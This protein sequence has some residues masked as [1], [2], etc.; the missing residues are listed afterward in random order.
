MTVH[1]VRL[2]AVV[3]QVGLCLVDC[4][5]VD[6]LHG[7]G[8]RRVG[9]DDRHVAALDAGVEAVPVGRVGEPLGG[10]ANV[11][12][13]HES[14]A[15]SGDVHHVD[16]VGRLVG[17]VDPVS[18]LVSLHRIEVACG[19]DGQRGLADDGVAARAGA[20]EDAPG[21]HRRDGGPHRPD[22]C[23]RGN[24][25]RPRSHTTE[26]CRLRQVRSGGRLGFPGGPRRHQLAEALACEPAYEQRYELGYPRIY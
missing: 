2:R 26:T 14:R 24:E 8:R 25:L 17:E 5:L 18:G 7:V 1:R 6:H 21:R 20:E 10:A 12:D 16:P 4:D 9:I 3:E 11:D 13:A 19:E 22:R 15:P 23:S